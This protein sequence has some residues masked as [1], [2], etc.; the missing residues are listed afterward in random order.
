MVL[1]NVVT[2]P[3]HQQA[4]TD[5]NVGGGRVRQQRQTP[6]FGPYNSQAR[7]AVT[8]S[9]NISLA[10][11]RL[12]CLLDCLVWG[13]GRG[14]LPAWLWA[15][16]QAGLK[17]FIRTAARYLESRD[18]DIMSKVFQPK[19]VKSKPIF[20]PDNV[21]VTDSCVAGTGCLG[22]LCTDWVCAACRLC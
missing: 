12:T 11:R 5:V 18:Y 19:Y 16:L 4:A 1:L 14:V 10:L 2:I 13:R 3:S 20:H 17:Y 9:C 8:V 15:T 6:F 21:L 22:I 7:L